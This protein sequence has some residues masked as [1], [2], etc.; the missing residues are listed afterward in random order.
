MP[1]WRCMADLQKHV[2]HKTVCIPLSTVYFIVNVNVCFLMMT[3]KLMWMEL[4][5]AVSDPSMS[6][7]L[8][9]G[10]ALP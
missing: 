1:Y 6:Q 9:V 7:L 3:I 10:A 4:T 5:R 2:P 8:C